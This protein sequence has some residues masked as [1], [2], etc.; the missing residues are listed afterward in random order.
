MP[1]R[2]DTYDVYV[3]AAGSIRI[4]DFNPYGGSTLPLLFSWSDLDALAADGDVDEVA[5]GTPTSDDDA[6]S[7]RLLP[8][9]RVVETPQ[10]VRPGLRTGVPVELYDQ[11]SGS[12]LSQLLA[13]CREEETAA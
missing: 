9:V 1:P 5:G 6:P 13:R 4:L 2:T 3:T 7:G 12:A 10:M 11:S 8:I